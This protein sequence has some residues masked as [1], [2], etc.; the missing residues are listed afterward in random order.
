MFTIPTI[1][2]AASKR[3][4]FPAASLYLPA[5]IVTMVSDNLP[6]VSTKPPAETDVLVFK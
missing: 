5:G 2:S 3:G 4:F 1:K 6:P